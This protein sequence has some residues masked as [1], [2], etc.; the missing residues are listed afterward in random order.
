LINPTTLWY[1]DL[2]GDNWSDG[3]IFTGCAA[4]GTGYYLSGDLAGGLTGDCNDDPDNYG[5]TVYPG[6]LEICDLQNN[7]CDAW[8]D[9]KI[10]NP[11]L[12]TDYCQFCENIYLIIPGAQCDALEDLYDATN[13][14]TDDAWLDDTN[15][16]T[17]VD[18]DSWYGVTV[19]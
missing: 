14:P 10:D 8:T 16:L 1:K 12:D 6:A 13:G 18:I 2:D 11:I 9:E 7:D 3:V 15:W 19:A 4:P 17:D 5:A